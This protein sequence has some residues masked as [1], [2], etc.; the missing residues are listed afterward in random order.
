MRLNRSYT[1]SACRAADGTNKPIWVAACR[2]SSS[3]S[4]TVS[5]P[6]QAA[7]VQLLERT[8][9]RAQLLHRLGEVEPGDRDVQGLA[10]QLLEVEHVTRR[11]QPQQARHPGHI[12]GTSPARGLLHGQEG[13]RRAVEPAGAFHLGDDAWG[14]PGCVVQ[15]ERQSPQGD[16]A[17]DLDARQAA[18]GAQRTVGVVEPAEHGLGRERVHPW[19]VGPVTVERPGTEAEG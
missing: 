3:Q 16:V 18:V 12:R 14:K 4:A 17:Q 10:G 19:G 15:P 1:S 2:A 9:Q 8:V 5:P 6:G 11:I 13:G 7:D